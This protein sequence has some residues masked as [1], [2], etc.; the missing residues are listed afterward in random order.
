MYR[1]NVKA[2]TDH[3]YEVRPTISST[4]GEDASAG[5]SDSLYRPRYTVLDCC[6]ASQH[7]HPHPLQLFISHSN[8]QPALFSPFFSFNSPFLCS[9]NAMSI[10]M[11]PDE[12][13]LADVRSIVPSVED[14][15]YDEGEYDQVDSDKG[16]RS[17]RSLLRRN[18]D[19][20]VAEPLR[21]ILYD[22][23]DCDRYIVV[24]ERL[25]CNDTRLLT[26]KIIPTTTSE[27]LPVNILA[28]S[29]GTLA[30]IYGSLRKNVVWPA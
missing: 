19:S 4:D 5:V 25:G 29:L 30:S 7:I 14:E 2:N 6:P 23:P 22:Q 9:C 11:L 15:T 28:D 13:M 24:H 27:R 10:E 18:A 12:P 20:T 16:H 1:K 8:T 21:W 3:V 17:C 26:V